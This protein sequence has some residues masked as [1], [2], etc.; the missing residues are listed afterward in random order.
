VADIDFKVIIATGISK[1]SKKTRSWKEKSV[2]D[3][4]TLLG[5]TNGYE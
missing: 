2:E 5:H 3:V 1:I 4:V